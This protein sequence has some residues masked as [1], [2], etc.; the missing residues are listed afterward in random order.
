MQYL[1]VTVQHVGGVDIFETTQDLVDEVLDVID[2]ERLLAVDDAMQVR[3]HQI[4]HDVNIFEV[5]RMWW[6]RNDVDYPNHILVRKLLHQFD[7]SQDAL[8]VD[9]ILESARYLFDRDFLSSLF[10]QR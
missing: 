1:K 7:L 5:V 9:G 4:L 8:C 2:G 6:R 3:L 10:V